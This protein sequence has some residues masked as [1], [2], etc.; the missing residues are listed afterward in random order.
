MS[1]L[2][3]GSSLYLDVRSMLPIPTGKC[4]GNADTF[5]RACDRQAVS[6]AYNDK[7]H[8]LISVCRRHILVYRV[9]D[10]TLWQAEDEYAELRR[11]RRSK[12]R[13]LAQRRILRDQRLARRGIE[14]RAQRAT[15]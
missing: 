9:L 2:I 4:D 10:N 14:T 5:F 11:C 7:V 15:R 6:F 8:G 3:R 1:K 13:W 12:W